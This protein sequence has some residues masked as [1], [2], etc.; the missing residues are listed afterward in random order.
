MNKPNCIEC[1]YGAL[2]VPEWARGQAVWCRIDE[3]ERACV[4]PFYQMGCAKF[5]QQEAA[6]IAKRVAWVQRQG[7]L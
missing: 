5:V 4:H 3:W 2:D 6:Q 1:V 7:R